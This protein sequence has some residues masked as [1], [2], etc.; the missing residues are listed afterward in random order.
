MAYTFRMS[1]WAR[2]PVWWGWTES[3]RN[4]SAYEADALPIEL[5]PHYPTCESDKP[6]CGNGLALGGHQT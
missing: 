1:N 3:N 6:G 5:Q 4:P 2:V